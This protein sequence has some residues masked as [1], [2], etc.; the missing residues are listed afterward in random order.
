MHGKEYL[1]TQKVEQMRRDRG[2]SLTWIYTRLGISRTS[3]YLLFTHGVLPEDLSRRKELLEKLSEL[4][5]ADGPGSLVRPTQ[6]MT[7]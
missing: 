5:G 6:A 3:G 7:A 2:V 1:D 4:L